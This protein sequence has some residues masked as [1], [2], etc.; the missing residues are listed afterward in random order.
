MNSNHGEVF[1]NPYTFVS[2]PQAVLRRKPPGHRVKGNEARYSGTVTV[3]WELKTPLL[4]PS[5]ADEEGWIE[6]DG[7]IRIPGSSLKG[8]VR[9][10]HEA[11][12]NGCLRIIDDGFT[13]SYRQPATGFDDEKQWRLAIVTA[14]EA[15]IPKR[16]QLTS[17]G[18]TEWVE[19]RALRNAR[20]SRSLP[21]SGDV[22]RILG[23]REQ[24]SLNRVEVRTVTGVEILASAGD[25]QQTTGPFPSGG[26][27]FLVTDTAAR[28]VTRNDRSLANCF[29]ASG[30]LSEEQVSFDHRGRDADAWAAFMAA[31]RGS[32]DRRLLE[33]GGRSSDSSSEWRAQSAYED[34][35]WPPPR[36][37]RIDPANACGRRT[38]QTGLLFRG[39]VVWLKY[40]GDRIEEIRL[41]Q[42]WRV[43]GQGAVGKRIGSAAPCPAPDSPEA[44]CLSCATFGSASVDGSHG[45]GDQTSYAGHVRFTSARSAEGISLREVSLAPMG[46]PNPGAGTFYLGLSPDHVR[47][48]AGT[49]GDG[50]IPSHWGTGE[51]GSPIRGR[52]FYWHADPDA[53]AE[54]WS[55]KNRSAAIPRYQ[56]V[57]RTRESVMARTARLVP[58]GTRFTASIGVDQL[59]QVG[60]DALLAALDPSRILHLTSHHRA[61]LPEYAVH[62]GGG[63]ALGLG[64]ATVELGVRLTTTRD[65]YGKAEPA[66]HEWPSLNTGPEAGRLQALLARAGSFGVNLEQLAVL[67]DRRAL[68]DLEPYVS[69]PPGASWSEFGSAQFRRSFEFFQQTNGQQLARGSRE[70]QVLP[71]VRASNPSLPVR[72]K[73]GRS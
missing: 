10:L 22:V 2:L 28:K 55:A 45:E 39:D 37:E 58:A 50:D 35:Y 38:K 41:A 53:Q 15:G 51:S 62:L 36:Q 20:R 33:Q 63:K 13:P 65:R 6:S 42:I 30:E 72:T 48:L 17:A 3:T 71:A 11:M 59:D 52:K 29:W 27:V 19:A 61:G 44:L 23:P 34:V 9:S 57:D 49:L 40:A 54:H 46:A 69:Y 8:A 14:A 1:V 26:R 66:S 24:T 70:W 43:R 25:A 47:G 56:D 67:L 31:C 68:G 60:V 21:T 18:S 12:F 16:L 4:L 5:C 64:S 73:R 7:S 32:N